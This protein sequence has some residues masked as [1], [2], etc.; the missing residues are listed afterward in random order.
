MYAIAIELSQETFESFYDLN[1][2]AAIQS[3]DN[4]LKERGF[5]K[6]FGIYLG[7]EN[8]T[9]VTATLAV[10]SMSKEFPW[11]K[12]GLVDIDLWRIEETADLMP[13]HLPTYKLS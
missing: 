2:N 4:F 5:I 11:L 7:D 12:Y 8:V 1:F 10:A 9:A 3:L 13:A 6:Q